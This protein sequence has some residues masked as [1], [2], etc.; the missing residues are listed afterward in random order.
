MLIYWITI[1]TMIIHFLRAAGCFQDRQ[2]SKGTRDDEEG[3]A[4]DALTQLLQS[5]RL[6]AK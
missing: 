4:P 1:Y 3:S 2:Q 6:A 5:P